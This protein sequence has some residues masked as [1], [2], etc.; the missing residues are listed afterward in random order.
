MMMPN[1]KNDE[2]LEALNR[3]DIKRYV[4]RGRPHAQDDTDALKRVWPAAFVR[5]VGE[6]SE[7]NSVAEA[8]IRVELLLR[9]VEMRGSDAPEAFAKVRARIEAG[10]AI[11][12]DIIDSSETHPVLQVILD[13]LEKKPN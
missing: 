3:I 10:S 11:L 8:N 7:S 1:S 2:L 9:G 12:D 6:P 4:E 13:E 5:W